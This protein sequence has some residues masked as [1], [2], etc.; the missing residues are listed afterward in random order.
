ML[1]TSTLI[2]NVRSHTLIEA[3]SMKIK[4]LKYENIQY[5]VMY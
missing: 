5:F 1:D 2:Q 4:L 3:R